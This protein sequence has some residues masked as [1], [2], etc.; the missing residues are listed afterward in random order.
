MPNS[1]PSGMFGFTIVWLG[2]IVSLLGTNMTGFGVTIWAYELTG[3]ATALA[4][5]GFFFVTP[6]LL[7]S[8]IAGA[9]V[10]R[11]DRKLMMMLSDLASGLATILI[12]V[13]YLA[14]KLQI[15]HLYLTGAIQG[16]FQT[17]Q[18]PAYSAAIT[19]MLSKEH[20]GRANGMMSLAESGSGIFAPLLAGALLG[21]IGLGGILAIDVITFVIAIGALLTVHVPNPPRTEE[22]RQGE[23][24]LLREAAYGFH[25][26]LARPSLLGLQIVFLLGNFF[27]GVS[28]AV[29]APMIL[30]STGNNELIFGSVNSVGAIGGV[31]GGVVMSA[32]GGPKRRVH[33]VL[34][35]WALAGLLGTT[36]M[37]LGRS[38]PVWAVASFIGAFLTPVI[39]GSNQAIWQAKV[40]PDVQGRV[41]SIRRLIAWFVNPIS[42]LI[43][44]PLADYLLEPAMRSGGW[45]S[46]SLGWLVGTGPGRGIALIFVITGLIGAVIGL[47]GYL[48][49]T[50]RN[51]ESLLPDYDEASPREGR[52][53][54]LE[55]LLAARR[56]LVS[57]PDSLGRQR[58]LK[59]VQRELR[60][61]GRQSGAG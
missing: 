16:T 7:F 13:L 20:Y 26:I 25:Y 10:D 33:G 5:V 38:L 57:E 50:V 8:P 22:G 58:A 47:G 14:G 40:A 60:E 49:H 3:S 55:Q 37:G 59:Q 35:G 53:K 41:F 21:F 61:L 51:A 48:F 30:A 52:A 28:F 15:W 54:R 17:F 23:G 29:Q 2:Q 12:L 11:H 43:A 45:L 39:N 31:V 36:L 18:W 56:R 24:S 32:W 1:R 34:A 27:L 44:G 6:M 46:G 42:M 4:L 19:T 9:I